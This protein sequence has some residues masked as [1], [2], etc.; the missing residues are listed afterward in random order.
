[1]TID[2]VYKVDPSHYNKL[3]NN[4]KSS[5]LSISQF[6]K[7][8]LIIGIDRGSRRRRDMEK[9]K[10]LEMIMKEIIF[11]IAENVVKQQGGIMSPMLL[12]DIKERHDKEKLLKTKSLDN[13]HDSLKDKISRSEAS[14]KRTGK[15]TVNL[16]KSIQDKPLI[17]RIGEE[18]STYHSKIHKYATIHSSSPRSSTKTPE[19]LEVVQNS[20]GRLRMMEEK[21]KESKDTLAV[22]E[23]HALL[24]YQDHQNNFSTL[25]RSKSDEVVADSKGK[26]KVYDDQDQMEPLFSDD[27]FDGN[28]SDDEEVLKLLRQPTLPDYMIKDLDIDVEDL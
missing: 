8:Q 16:N 9:R 15:K 22:L 7:R 27:E 18:R 28:L 12:Q 1:M 19:A 2:L 6:R 13:V 20:V 14:W 11:S 25:L 17:R 5:A 26:G 24:S 3:N 23:Q 4:N 10:K 21:F